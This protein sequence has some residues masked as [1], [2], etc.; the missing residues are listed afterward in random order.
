MTKLFHC[1]FDGSGSDCKC[2][3]RKADVEVLMSRTSLLEPSPRY[4]DSVSHR[5]QF[6]RGIG[7]HVAHYHAP[8]SS[9][10]VVNID[11]LFARIASYANVLN[12]PKFHVSVLHYSSLPLVS[13]FSNTL[14][15]VRKRV[16]FF[17]LG[18]S[19]QQALTF[20]L[21]AR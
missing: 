19:V 20:V 10:H 8:V 17:K 4:S 9:P 21:T 15:H 3:L 1:D 14:H 13:L 18:C 5:K 6:R 11:H 12:H 16:T 2:A 7:N